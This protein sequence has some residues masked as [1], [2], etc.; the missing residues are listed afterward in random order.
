MLKMIGIMLILISSTKI[1]F[2]LASRLEKRKSTLEGFK[3][4]LSMLEAEISFAQNSLSR[5]F[6]NISHTISPKVISEFYEDV[7]MTIDAEKKPLGAAWSECL[8]SF[9]AKMCIS[10]AD[11]QVLKNFSNRLGKSDI[12]NELKNIHAAAALI[13]MQLEDAKN[14][15]NTSKKMYQSA[16][17][18]TGILVV[19]L[20]F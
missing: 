2:S 9:S 7:Y 6:Y 20:L 15:C 14:A 16:G 3:N 5:A 11:A 1:G 10:R 18:L 13:D 12:E 8:D 17:I 4:S 19:V